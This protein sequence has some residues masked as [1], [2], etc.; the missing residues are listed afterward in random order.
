[1]VTEQLEQRG[2]A[3]PRVLAAM[4]AVPREAFVPDGLVDRA[5]A[6]AALPLA[7]GQTISQPYVVAL[8]TEAARIAPG[9]KVLEVGTGYGYAAAVLGK[10]AR[11]VHTIERRA[12][13]AKE[14][15]ER[16]RRLGCDNVRVHVG[17][18]TLGLPD[19]APF[20]AILVTAGG[21]RVPEALR[22]Q[23]AQGGRLVI[24]V[25]PTRLMQ[26]LTRLTRTAKDQYEEETLGD[27]AFV[28]LVGDEGWADPGGPLGS[29]R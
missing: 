23:L 1:M 18:G 21:P 7:E 15:R 27:V 28:P 19:E 25:G 13:L 2:I 29:F 14:A 20:D 24:P 5:Y 10:I 3:D 17:D 6:D 4:R 12:A 16:L 22:W 11:E 8:M 9:D 26:T